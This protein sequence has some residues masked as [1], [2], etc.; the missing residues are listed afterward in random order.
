MENVY[1]NQ[2][3]NK[4]NFKAIEK[5]VGYKLDKGEKEYAQYYYENGGEGLPNFG[6]E[7]H[8]EIVNLLG[9]GY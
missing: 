5:A 4:P 8:Q 1:Y 9:L 7:E 6:S 3:K 2:E